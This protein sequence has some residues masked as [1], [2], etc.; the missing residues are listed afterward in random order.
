MTKR[1]F[2]PRQHEPMM[3]AYGFSGAAEAAGL[4]VCSGQLGV[5]ADGAL[6]SDPA[7]QFD[8]AFRNVEAVLREAGVGFDDLVELVSFHVGLQ[9]HLAAFVEVKARF[10]RAPFPAWTAIGITELALPGALVEIRAVAAK[11]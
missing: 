9:Q 11:S 3:R 6:L 7:A 4:V 5:G 1:T 8:A 2:T 10:V